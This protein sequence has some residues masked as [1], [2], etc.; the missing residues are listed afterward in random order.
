MLSCTTAHFG[1]KSPRL[2]TEEGSSLLFFAGCKQQA[3]LPPSA[4]SPSLQVQMS[5]QQDQ[6]DFRMKLFEKMQQHLNLYWNNHYRPTMNFLDSMP[7]NRGWGWGAPWTEKNTTTHPLTLT[8]DQSPW[9]VHS[10][11]AG[12]S[13]SNQ[14]E[15]TQAHGEPA[16]WEQRGPCPNPWPYRASHWTTAGSKWKNPSG[17]FTKVYV[18][19]SGVIKTR[20]DRD[21]GYRVSL[22]L[23]WLAVG[24]TDIKGPS[25]PWNIRGRDPASEDQGPGRG[26][27]Y[28][29]VV[30]SYWNVVQITICVFLALAL[31]V[32]GYFGQHARGETGR[33][34]VLGREWDDWEPQTSEIPHCRWSALCPQVYFSLPLFSCVKIKK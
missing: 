11:N 4:L 31:A 34:S 3:T 6:C 12:G 29:M 1:L 23:P 27:I 20:L 24:D 22:V 10:C 15:P 21:C 33:R 2:F 16:R 14:R 7:A 25:F 30:E 8:D 28:K 13:H 26:A 19:H 5:L 9:P 17:G 18:R 32:C